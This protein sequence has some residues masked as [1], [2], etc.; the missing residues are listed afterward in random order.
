[1]RPKKSPWL[2]EQLLWFL[3]QDLAQQLTVFQVAQFQ[4]SISHFV[5]RSVSAAG[6]GAGKILACTKREF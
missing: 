3:A 1:M 6:N 5:L 4:V 2:A